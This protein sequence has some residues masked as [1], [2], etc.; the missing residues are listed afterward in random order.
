LQRAKFISP[1]LTMWCYR[2]ARHRA[3]LVSECFAPT[4]AT[5]RVTATLFLANFRGSF[6][7]GDNAAQKSC[8]RTLYLIRVF[9]RVSVCPSMLVCTFFFAIAQS[10]LV[11]HF[12]LLF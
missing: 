4:S 8:V 12:I 9:T 5:R 7:T 1:W 2:C 6:Q 11:I 3:Y 10:F